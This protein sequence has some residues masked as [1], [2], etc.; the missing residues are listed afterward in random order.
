MTDDE[1]KQLIASNAKSIEALSN[2]LTNDQKERRREQTNLYQY[3]SRLASAQSSFYEVQADYYHQL[4]TLQERQ[5]RIEERQTK[6]EERQ[7]KTEE[8]LVKL[9]ERLG[10]PDDDDTDET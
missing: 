3:L 2:A 9:F 6:I 1:I 8:R 5:T 4:A 10:I 7:S